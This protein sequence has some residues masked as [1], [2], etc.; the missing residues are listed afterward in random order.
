MRFCGYGES[1]RGYA[2]RGRGDVGSRERERGE[3]G[4][5]EG[6]GFSS[7]DLR[8]RSESRFLPFL[9]PHFFSLLLHCPKTDGVSLSPLT[10]RSKRRQRQ[11]QQ[12]Q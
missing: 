11:Q 12:Q 7:E 8:L 1:G 3:E 5:L 4:N 9:S 2:R 10:S 6:L